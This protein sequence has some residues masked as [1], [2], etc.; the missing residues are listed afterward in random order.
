MSNSH[1][2]LEVLLDILE[3]D[4]ALDMARAHLGAN[5]IGDLGFDSVAFAIGIVAIE[6]RLGVLLSEQE[7]MS[8]RTLGDVVHLIDSALPYRADDVA[9]VIRAEHY[10]R[11]IRSPAE[12]AT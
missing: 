6:E 12:E 2:G 9:S 7:L 3:T 1:P 11:L 8:C 10:E 4:L 5:L